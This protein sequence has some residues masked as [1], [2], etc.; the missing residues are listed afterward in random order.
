MSTPFTD[1]NDHR[2]AFDKLLDDANFD[3]QGKFIKPEPAPAEGENGDAPPD[4]NAAKVASTAENTAANQPPPDAATGKT[5]SQSTASEKTTDATGKTVTAADQGKAPAATG[6]DAPTD[7]ETEDQLKT[8]LSKPGDATG[9]EWQM[10]AWREGQT[11]KKKLMPIQSQ[12]ERINSN[13]RASRGLDF[14]AAIGEPDQPIASAAAKLTELAPTRAVELRNHY[15][16]ETLDQYPDHAL[17]YVLGEEATVDE[18]KQGL[19]LLRSGAQPADKQPQSTATAASVDVPK[20]DGMDDDEWETFKIDYPSA[21]KA[22]QAQYAA[23]Q[24]P[25]ATGTSDKSTADKP[26]DPRITKL[27][28]ELETFKNRDIE[29]RLQQ[30][31]TEV[32]NEGQKLEAE[33]FSVVEERL[34][35]LGLEPDTAKDDQATITLKKNT[36]DDIRKQA[37]A[38][39]EGPNGPG[40]WDDW[41]LCTDEQKA[42]RELEMKVMKLLYNK[43]K[44]AWDYVDQLKARADLT[45]ERVV[46][47]NL[48]RY[49]AAML[50]PTEK[51][52]NAGQQAPRPEIIGGTTAAGSNGSTKTPWLDPNFR[53]PG[54]DSMT[55]MQRYLDSHEALPGR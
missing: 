7:E 10:R 1:A 34:R 32:N 5:A 6:K 8:R 28:S 19:A 50:Q 40:G 39:F 27:T 44:S 9:N 36:A 43:D 12:L 35:E 37:V 24:K 30:Y 29:T 21:F 48:K 20:P 45:L 3:E 18:V 51:P 26:D 41:S 55:A 14:V 42:N 33:V 11:L 52:R 15:Y 49:N 38:E 2:P 46:D 4:P 54:E 22:M 47:A 16:T 17:S 53:L 25:G 31:Q 13:E 23:A